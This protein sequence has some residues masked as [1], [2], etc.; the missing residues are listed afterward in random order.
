MRAV[1]TRAFR[2]FRPISPRCAR[3]RW[4]ATNSSTT[5]LDS[6]SIPRWLQNSARA[7]QHR[8]QAERAPQQPV[9]DR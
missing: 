6:T 2:L 1:F 8:Q 7:G 3:S 4:H 9:D 5:L